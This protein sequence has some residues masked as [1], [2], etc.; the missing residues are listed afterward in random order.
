MGKNIVKLE[1]FLWNKDAAE[2]FIKNDPLDLYYLLL[3]LQQNL[4]SCFVF[5][6]NIAIELDN[7]SRACVS[8]IVCHL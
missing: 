1:I 4:T 7:N 3:L 6:H 5:V 8:M 2:T